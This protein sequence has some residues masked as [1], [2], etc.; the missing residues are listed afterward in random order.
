M[1]KKGYTLIEIIVVIALI[2]AIGT[3]GV[4]GLSKV[5]SNSKEQRYN[6]MIDDIKS[7][8]NTYFTVYSEKSGYEYL[9][10]SLYNNGR[11]VIQISTLKEALLIDENL[12]NPK[13]NQDVN[14]CVVITYNT[15][16]NYKVCPYEDNCSCS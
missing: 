14:G 2:A 16:L 8:G 3:F 11:L 12:K 10:N 4:V 6:E 1:N 5:I 15:E 7:A 9:K 13:N